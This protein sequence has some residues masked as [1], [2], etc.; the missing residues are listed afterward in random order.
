MWS[1]ISAG[2]GFAVGERDGQEGSLC[3][4]C[5]GGKRLIDT[6]QPSA[7]DLLAALHI[8][9]KRPLA[10]APLCWTVLQEAATEPARL[11]T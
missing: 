6:Y 8:K 1:V 11:H 5:E 3:C 4:C 9:E 10:A 2:E 7:K